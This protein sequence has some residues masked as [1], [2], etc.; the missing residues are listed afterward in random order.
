MST[1]FLDTER[2][3]PLP[4][5]SKAALSIFK[6]FRPIAPFQENDDTNDDGEQEEDQESFWDQVIK[7]R[8]VM[9]EH[10]EDD[11]YNFDRKEIAK[12]NNLAKERYT[13]LV[14]FFKNESILH[15]RIFL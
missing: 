2:S 10:Q 15:A 1:F 13:G 3:T 4:S 14:S 9:L 7:I 12:F 5:I 6:K 8:N 11:N